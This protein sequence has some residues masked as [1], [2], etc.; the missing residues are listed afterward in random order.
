MCVVGHSALINYYDKIRDF[1]TSHHK[2]L[3]S[4]KLFTGDLLA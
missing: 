2:C 4:G 1:F 3:P